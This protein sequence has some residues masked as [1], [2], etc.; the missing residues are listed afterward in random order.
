MTIRAVTFDLFDTLVDLFVETTPKAEW[1]GRVV[2]QSVVD[3]HARVTRHVSLEPV[4]FLDHLREVDRH[5]RA[6]HY[7]EGREV[8]SDLRFGALVERLGIDSDPLREDL[9]LTHMGALRGQVGLLTHHVDVVAELGRRVRIA[10]C[11]N[12]SHSQTALSVLAES[13]LDQYLHAIVISED[14]GIRKP[15]REIFEAALEAVGA[16]PEET[17]H[18]GDNL[19]ADVRGASELG[20]RTA[21]ITRRIADP[22]RA[23]A[24]FE[25]PAPDWRIADLAEL[26]EIVP[27]APSSVP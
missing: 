24:D 1:A 6:S 5:F 4:D 10:V 2:P 27:R 17:L 8:S 12:F 16:A 13:Q 18:V 22:D 7:A 26:L 9:V 25:G 23:L 20:L 3:L 14:V 15:R 21:W 11:S 19:E